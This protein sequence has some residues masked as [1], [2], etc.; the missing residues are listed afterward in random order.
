MVILRS[1]FQTSQLALSF[2][3]GGDA[4]EQ[5]VNA[6]FCVLD[7]HDLLVELSQNSVSLLTKLDVEEGDDLLSHDLYIGISI[8]SSQFLLQVHEL[9]LH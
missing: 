4:L 5:F 3:D 1:C 7:L 9:I 2:M 8:S 6:E